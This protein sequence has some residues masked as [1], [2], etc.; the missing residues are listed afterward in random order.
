MLKRIESVQTDT[1]ESVIHLVFRDGTRLDIDRNYFVDQ[2]GVYEQLADDDFF[3]KAEIV[4]DGLTLEW[5]GE[6]VIDFFAPTLWEDFS[7]DQDDES[8]TGSRRA[9]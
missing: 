1:T 3:A 5:S 6:P 7:D 2:G 8:G 4:N 9:I